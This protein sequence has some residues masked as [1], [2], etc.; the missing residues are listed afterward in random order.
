MTALPLARAVAHSLVSR[1]VKRKLERMRP[2]E[3]PTQGKDMVLKEFD[4][5][6]LRTVGDVLY[7]LD[8]FMYHLI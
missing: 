4:K 5:R 2:D 3:R 1:Y 8:A 6:N 7:E